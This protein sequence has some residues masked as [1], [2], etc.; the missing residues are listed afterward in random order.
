MKVIING[1]FFSQRITGV[2][3]FAIE[4]IRELDK[5]VCNENYEL[6]LPPN[7]NI[8]FDLKNIKVKRSD[9]LL[10]GILWDIFSFARYVKNEN[11]L[12]VNLCNGINLHNPSIVCIHDITYKVNPSFYSGKNRLKMYWNRF[13]CW[14]NAKYADYIIT[15][16]EFSKKEIMRSY[17][18]NNEKIF[19]VY[20][21]W[22]HINRINDK[23]VDIKTRYPFLSPGNY[24]FSISTLAKNKNFKWILH[25]AKNN[26]DHIFVIAG[27]GKLKE[28]ADASGLSNLPNVKFLGYVTDEEAISLIKNCK[29]FIF[30]SLYEGFGLPPLEAM[31]TGCKNIIVSDIEVMH[32]IFGDSV[33]YID[34]L[35]FDYKIREFPDHTASHQ[36]ILEKYSWEKTSLSLFNLIERFNNDYGT[37][38]NKT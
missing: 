29:A 19:V 28:T 17:H 27:G 15:V 20:N 23:E 16:S 36:K 21:A 11:A 24:F 8:P 32:E 2:Q 25:A 5:L 10:K 14:F 3:R 30:P 13:S 33:D 1:R 26:Q 31:G 12:S 34:P 6:Y 4:I 18:V 9:S 22:Q 7:C 38:A 37:K 35:N